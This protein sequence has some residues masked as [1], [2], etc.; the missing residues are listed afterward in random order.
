[1]RYWKG[2]DAAKLLDP[3]KHTPSWCETKGHWAK[4]VTTRD[5][6]AGLWRWLDMKDS[7]L[8]P[9]QPFMLL[10]MWHCKGW[11]AKDCLNLSNATLCWC[12]KWNTGQANF[13]THHD[14]KHVVMIIVDPIYQSQPSATIH[15]TYNEILEG[16]RCC[17]TL[18]SIQTHSILVWN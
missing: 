14:S 17:E 13:N 7:N 18:G 11:D 16:L 10:T 1:M 12:Q 2:W 3:S 4:I 8:N 6:K 5:S 9:A 15:C